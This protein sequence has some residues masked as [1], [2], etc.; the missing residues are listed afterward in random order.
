MK[1]GVKTSLNVK[2][3]QALDQFRGFMESLYQQMIIIVN[4]E[5]VLFL[6][7]CS[8]NFSASQILYFNDIQLKLYHYTKPLLN[9]SL[10]SV[11]RIVFILFDT[12]IKQ[13]GK[14]ISAYYLLLRAKK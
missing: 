12:S 11:L 5:H 1:S 13:L 2:G 10:H 4:G 8:V 6:A 7:Y 9:G 3:E 14:I